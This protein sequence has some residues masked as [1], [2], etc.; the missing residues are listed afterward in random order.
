MIIV[1]KSVSTPEFVL[2]SLEKNS[3]NTYSSRDGSFVKSFSYDEIQ[4]RQKDICPDC[5]KQIAK[6]INLLHYADFVGSDME[7]W[8]MCF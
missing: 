7:K 1:V 2:P 6:L 4:V 5:Q 3:V 8:Y